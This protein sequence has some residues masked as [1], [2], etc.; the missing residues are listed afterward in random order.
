MSHKLLGHKWFNVPYASGLFYCKSLDLM[1][2]ILAGSTQPAYLSTTATS[3][4]KDTYF[5]WVSSVASPLHTNLDNSRRFAALPL[6]CALLNLGRKGYEDIVTRN[7][8]FA[9]DIAD[10]IAPTP[11]ETQQSGQ[12]GNRENHGSKWYEVLNL[13]K[14]AVVING[15]TTVKVTVPL[16]VVLF[17]ARDVEGVPA[18]Y[19]R[20]TYSGRGQSDAA[21]AA[22]LVRDINATGVMYVS[23]GAYEGGAVRIA[24]SNWM[25]GLNDS[26][27]DIRL[28]KKTLKQVMM[29]GGKS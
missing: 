25:T 14:L 22:A 9:R 17:R 15:R 2:S 4:F 16:N 24:V 12:Q 21:A 5:E 13:R 7:V 26:G 18:I 23:P 28:V 20:S 29:N 10:W 8:Q 11:E 3:A 27:K 6:Y 1:R 19:R